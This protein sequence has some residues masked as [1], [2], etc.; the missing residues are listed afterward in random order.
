MP[1]GFD[2]D[3]EE[4]LSARRGGAGGGGAGEA[5]MLDM[6][7]RRIGGAIVLAG[8]L[9]GFGMY[10]G[11]D[12]VEA[13]RY[14]VYAADGEVFRVNTE[15]GTVIACNGQRCMIVLERGQDLAEDQG[16]TLFRVPAGP[17]PVA[18][19][20]PAP[21]PAAQGGQAA[22]APAPAPAQEDPAR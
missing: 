11:G 1:R 17:A 16:N 6:L 4:R 14:Q 7:S 13:P 8:A 9:I 12:E 2:D 3:F 18:L 19:P 20:A 15:S 21:A 10:A 5:G 22:P